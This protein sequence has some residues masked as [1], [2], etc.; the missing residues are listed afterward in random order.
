MCP[1]YA[2]RSPRK[3]TLYNTGE[4]ILL[5]ITENTEDGVGKIYQFPNK[6]HTAK[7]QSRWHSSTLS[8]N[9]PGSRTENGRDG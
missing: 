8:H 4:G 6:N 3:Y 9:Q 1:E 7:N 5:N 2:V